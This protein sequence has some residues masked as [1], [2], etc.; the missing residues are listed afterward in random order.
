VGLCFSTRLRFHLLGNRVIGELTVR[1]WSNGG[2]RLPNHGQDFAT[3]TI[4]LNSGL[5]GVG[6]ADQIA[7]DPLF[8]SDRSLAA[9]R[10][11]LEG[12]PLP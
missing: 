8:N 3:L 7:I 1:H 10:P 4:R 6:R 12:E 5:F 9:N 11:R 2:V